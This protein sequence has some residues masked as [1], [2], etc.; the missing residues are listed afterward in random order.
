MKT[1]RPYQEE[2][3]IAVDEFLRERPDNPCVCIPTGGGKSF[4]MASIINK[5]KAGHPPFRCIILAHREELVAQNAKE[6][7]DI[8]PE[9][10]IGIYS[11]G[12]GRRDEEHSIIFASID[13]V[14]RRWGNFAPWDVIMVDE[15]HRI[16]ASGEGKYLN[17]IKN[18]KLTN[19]NLR[20]VGFTATPFR[21]SGPICHKNHI[22]NAI[23]YE[24]NVG[25]LIAKGYL[26]RLRSRIGDVQPDLSNVK[27][28]SGGDYIEKSL[29]AAVDTPEVVTKAIRSAMSYIIAEKRKSIIFFCVDVKHCTQVSNELRKYGLDA[30]CVTAKTPKSE[31]VR[32]RE[33]FKA[34]TIH[35]ICNV[36]VYTEGFDA[37]RID[38]VVLLRPTL[39]KGLYVQMV[40]RGLRM[41]L[42]KLFC[43][44]LD[45]A[46]CIDEHGPIDCI[47]AGEVKVEICPTCGDAFSRAIRKCPNC[48]WE[49]PK[50]EIERAEAEEREKKLH[51]A[52]ASRR[53]IIGSEP[54]TI[55]VDAVDVFRHKKL[56][57]PDSIRVEYRCGLSVFREW[58]CLD[59]DGFAQRKSRDWWSK[60]FGS[61]EAK[62]VTVNS[63]LEDMFLGER[64][65]GVTSTI[66]VIRR[67]KYTE[68]VDYKLKEQG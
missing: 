29:A 11:A 1:L 31:R 63:A 35:A 41:F 53:A 33:A 19:P 42:G 34:G 59:H 7:I 36:G 47:D 25:E 10:D 64:I 2:A 13:S 27:R 48:G 52:E 32:I 44:I 8:W 15:A 12:L 6:M 65:K 43:L 4:I 23:C 46:H 9:G 16:P 55:G 20:V 67:G 58:I 61:E 21:M 24:A 5:W 38:C 30:P 68:I 17:F 56:N 18:S 40:G 37:Q 28:N 49:I 54:E 45:Y 26:C 50:Q 60:R 62:L 3:V 14:H 51:E 22:M 57:S 66:T 39:S